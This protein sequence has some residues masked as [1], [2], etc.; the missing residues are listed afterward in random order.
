MP[1]GVM[2]RNSVA[3]SEDLAAR[4]YGRPYKGTK[5]S[6]LSESQCSPNEGIC[7]RYKP[8]LLVRVWKRRGSRVH[9]GGCGREL[10]MPCKGK[11]KNDPTDT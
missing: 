7:C 5:T 4:A 2:L 1:I 10:E 6:G 3:K 11:T 9:G 8:I